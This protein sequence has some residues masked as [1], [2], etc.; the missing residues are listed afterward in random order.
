MVKIKVSEQTAAAIRAGEEVRILTPNGLTCAHTDSS[1]RLERFVRYPEGF[2]SSEDFM[3]RF[4]R[5][6]GQE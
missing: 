5:M 2:L 6:T 1:E 3:R 4:R